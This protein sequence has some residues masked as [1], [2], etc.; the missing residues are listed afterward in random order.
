VTRNFGNTPNYFE[1]ISPFILDRLDDF[2]AKGKN[3]ADYAIPYMWGVSGILYNTNKVDC[4]RSAIVG[5]F[6]GP[7]K[8]RQNADEGQL[9][10]C[11]RHGCRLWIP[12]MI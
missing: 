4:R 9:L 5:M 6:L 7:K 1:H 8:Q 11:L 3:A 2:S 12:R 10:G